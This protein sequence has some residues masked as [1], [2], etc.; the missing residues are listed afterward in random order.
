[1]NFQRKILIARVA[2][3]ARVFASREFICTRATHSTETERTAR[4]V[5]RK[6]RVQKERERE[7]LELVEKSGN[8]I[9]HGKRCTLRMVN[10]I[11]R[12]FRKRICPLYSG[13]NKF[14]GNGETGERLFVERVARKK[15]MVIIDTLPWNG[16]IN[17]SLWIQK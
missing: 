14:R 12:A 9:S 3:L 11:I 4:G 5:E 10:F 13:A 7:V 1:M 8:L 16:L 17:G 2:S 15:Q 6:E